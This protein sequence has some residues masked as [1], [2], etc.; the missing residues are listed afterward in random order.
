VLKMPRI[1]DGVERGFCKEYV[2]RILDVVGIV[3]R[4]IDVLK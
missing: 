1:L 4:M 2:P 3:E